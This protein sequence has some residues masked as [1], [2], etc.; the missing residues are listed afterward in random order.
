M[1]KRIFMV[2]P[3]MAEYEDLYIVVKQVAE[4]LGA[5]VLRPDG[6][7]ISINVNVSSLRCP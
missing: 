7:R 1:S 3:L 2:C 5:T 6:L 4:S